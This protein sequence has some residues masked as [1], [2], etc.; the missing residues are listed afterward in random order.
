MALKAEVMSGA[1]PVFERHACELLTDQICLLL[2][3]CWHERPLERPNAGK[4]LEKL[5]VIIS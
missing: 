1:R 3:A 4:V 5:E 2:S